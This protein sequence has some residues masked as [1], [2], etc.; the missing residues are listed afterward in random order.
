MPHRAT[1]LLRTFAT[2]DVQRFVF[3]RPDGFSFSPGQATELAL[4]RDGWREEGRPFTMTSPPEAP[5]L[6]FTIKAYPAHD[7]V[8]S[9]L[10]GLEPGEDVLLDDPFDTYA[11]GGPGVFLAGGAG[12]TPFLAILRDLVRRGEIDQQHLI[13]SNKT[14]RDIICEKELRHLLGDRLTLTCTDASGPG[15]DD[16]VIDRAYLEE[17]LPGR[18]RRFYVC[19]PPGFVEDMQR[20]LGELGASAQDIVV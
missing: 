4:D 3:S 13:F 12:I 17:K 5:V 6:E 9:R 16:R 8:T 10:H 2:H 1:L 15:L 18:D 7:G 19:G 14:P 20:I 11:Y